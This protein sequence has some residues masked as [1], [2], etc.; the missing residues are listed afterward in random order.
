MLRLFYQSFKLLL[1]MRREQNE[2]FLKYKNKPIKMVAAI[3]CGGFIFLLF[4]FLY[5]A[6]ND[7]LSEY[8]FHS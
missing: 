2:F 3:R 7:N 8:L 6:F 5:G 1:K 4:S